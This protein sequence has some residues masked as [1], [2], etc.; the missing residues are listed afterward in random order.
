MSERDRERGS[1]KERKKT[2]RQKVGGGQGWWKEGREREKRERRRIFFTEC[3]V[4][5]RHCSKYVKN[6]PCIFKLI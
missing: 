2:G 1:R 5:T 6:A 4:C 3:L